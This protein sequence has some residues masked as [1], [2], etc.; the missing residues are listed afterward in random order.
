MSGIFKDYHV[1]IDY[2]TSNSCVGIYMNGTVQ[3]VPNKIGER[4]TPSIVCF[5]DDN[6]GKAL[7]GEETLNQKLDNY[8]NTIYEVK[9]F[10]GLNYE[11][12][13]EEEYGK[14]LNY[15]V[16]N[17]DGIPKIKVNVNGNDMYYSAE[18]ISSLIIKKMVQCA[19]DFI[20]E[21]EPGI[22]LTKAI[23]T[24]PAHFRDDQKNAVK[25]AAKLAGIDVPRIINEP[26]AAALAYGI[27]HNL[28]PEISNPSLKKIKTLHTSVVKKDGDAGEAPLAIEI[29][30]KSQE[31]AIVFDLGGGT[32]DITILNIRK[33][34]EGII[35][36]EVE[37]TD[38]DTHLGGSDFDNKL[39]DFC[40][41]DFCIK[42]GNKEEMVRQDKKSCKRLK[43]KCEN[44]KKLLTVTQQTIINIEN[45]YGKEDLFVSITRNEFD[46]LCKDLYDKI[47]DLI[48][49]VMGDIG[50]CPSDIDEIILVGAA[51]RMVGVKDLLHRIFG[52]GK[53]KDNLDPDEAVAFG[54]TMEAA[55]MEEKDKI[56]FILQD[57]TAYKL[58]IATENKD[59]NDKKENGEKMYS[60]IKKYSKIP[61]SSEKTFEVE[62]NQN[63]P[64]IDI[65]IF[66]GN[67]NYIKNNTLL[68][69]MH[70]DNINK[71]GKIEYKVKFSVDV[72]S[73]L[74]A[75]VTIDSLGIKKEEIIKKVTHA[76]L[77]KTKKKIKICK[78]HNLEP[79]S[80]LL[81][82]IKISRQKLS[83]SFDIQ[84]K[85]ENLKDCC[86]NI[87]KI[88][89]H[90]MQFIKDNE[91]IY[92]KIYINTN[93]LFG[94][95]I[96][97]IKI[98]ID[99]KDEIKE[100][101]QKIKQFMNNL[102]TQVGYSEELLE[103][104]AE[105]QQIEALKNVFYEIFINYM[106]L[107][108]EQGLIKKNNNKKFSRYY[109]K[110]YFEREFYTC[111]K[112]V[113]END[114]LKIDKSLRERYEKLKNKNEEELKKVNSFAKFIEQKVKTGQFM[115]GKTGFTMVGKKIEE[116][117]KNI[118]NLSKDD[119]LEILDIF[120]S[121]VDSFDK[122]D[123]S[124]GEAYCLFHLIY[125]NY[126]I[127]K[128]GYDKL[129]K[130]L[131][132]LKSI[133][134]SKF[135]EN[136]DWINEAKNLIKELEE[137]NKTNE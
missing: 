51:T 69:E 94:Y 113:K 6:K 47:E 119:L 66:E 15:E 132:R 91:S 105:I 33:N 73:Q 16:I 124:M 17:Q 137:E 38:G 106:E 101:I 96:E 9:R 43:I 117:E 70:I 82:S 103:D 86:Q 21:T 26:T 135:D 10:I 2:G 46:D 126:K 72:N 95:Y 36:F 23:I 114:L 115:Y 39:I 18:E 93:E 13:M 34:N 41:K 71:L 107:M 90:Y 32:L 37:S 131:E 56:N 28:A 49:Q 130:Y 68:G 84:N 62:L 79:F 104:F 54:A 74:T 88:I 87:E 52:E 123:N 134:F 48:Y 85:L 63:Y 128:K 55:K 25:N 129:W 80:I 120:Q 75:T 64:N 29:Q 122:K 53:V 60:I 83:E 50:K 127:F 112:Y 42:T 19:E 110:L 40:I 125:I 97:L 57:I 22:K 77:D 99:K 116:Y 5:T 8:K 44:A 27:G 12:F 108:N 1:G 92:E 14:N 65:R 121:M 67:D 31:N 61:S 78:N 35:N 58:G 59:P 118:N 20:A 100:I 24:V 136:Y 89:E 76:Y 111:K 3:I 30:S 102:I 98:N 81:E 11:E 45:F 7:V 133:L 109:S 4:T